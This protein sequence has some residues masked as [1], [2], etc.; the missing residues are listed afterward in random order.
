MGGGRGVRLT[1]IVG[2]I[3]HSSASRLMAEDERMEAWVGA[4]I[5]EMAPAA[6]RVVEA[7]GKWGKGVGVGETVSH[8]ILAF[9]S[10]DYWVC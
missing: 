6:G 8:I 2:R 5:Q 1:V 4:G 9:L 3:A 10:V 7:F